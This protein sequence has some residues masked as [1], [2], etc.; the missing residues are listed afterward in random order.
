MAARFRK[1][2]S[3]KRTDLDQDATTALPEI[4]ARGPLLQRLIRLHE[5]ARPKLALPHN[6]TG[7]ESE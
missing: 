4:E 1:R 5:V 2:A 6:G 3:R 7:L